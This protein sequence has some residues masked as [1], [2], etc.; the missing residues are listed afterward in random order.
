MSKT[1]KR[2]QDNLGH[3]R[4]NQNEK[5]VVHRSNIAGYKCIE[6]VQSI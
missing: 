5:K 4:R 1:R 6:A 2:E 3:L